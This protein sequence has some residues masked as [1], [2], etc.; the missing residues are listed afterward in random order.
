MSFK[1][2]V[3]VLLIPLKSTSLVLV[4]ISSM[5]VPTRYRFH[6]RQAKNGKITTF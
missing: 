6:A 3:V 2:I 4:M 5:S 1:I